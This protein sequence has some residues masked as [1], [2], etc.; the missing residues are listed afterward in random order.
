MAEVG[1]NVLN[2]EG[3]LRDL[4]EVM[5]EIGGKWSSLT[6]EQ[7]VYLAQTMAGQRQYSNLVALFD[8]FD[9]YEKTLKVA[10]GAAGTLE[11]QSET[12]LEGTRAHLM[13]L[14]ASM[15]D[16][17]DSFLNTDSIEGIADA[18]SMVATAVAGIVDSLGG[19]Q[20]ILQY[21]VGLGLST[22]ATH[23]ARSINTTITNFQLAKKRAEEF[24]AVLTSIEALSS[25]Q[26][27]DEDTRKLLGAKGDV[28]KY[29]RFA[30]PEQWTTTQQQLNDI[31]KK[32]QEIADLQAKLNP[33]RENLKLFSKSPFE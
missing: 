26:R 28:F 21:I 32:G 23:I 12:V 1:I 24:R 29:A 11:E 9:Q 2:T 3:K 33:I 22:F 8:N 25:N 30:T 18:L 6:R 19:G 31:A 27:L 16:I 14:K 4:G 10:Q 7:Q 13:Q 15:E 17:F 5:E 20:P